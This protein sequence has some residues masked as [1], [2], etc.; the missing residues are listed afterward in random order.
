MNQLKRQLIIDVQ[1]LDVNS[2]IDMFNYLVSMNLSFMENI[3]GVFFSLNDIPYETLYKIKHRLS[4]LDRFIQHDDEMSQLLKDNEDPNSTQHQ[5]FANHVAESFDT[6][7]E[8]NQET[9]NSQ[10]LTEKIIAQQIFGNAKLAEYED[11]F[12]DM[13]NKHN[14]MNKKHSIYI[15]YSVAKKKYNKQ[16]LSCDKKFDN[17]YL[18]ELEEDQYIF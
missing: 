3:N 10:R 9:N 7:A 14:K 17:F 15:R 18:N 8:D 16:S 5:I 4:M 11:F 2:K 12:K 1:K 6:D 13:E